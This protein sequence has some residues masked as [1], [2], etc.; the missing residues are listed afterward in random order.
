[1]ESNQYKQKTKNPAK[2]TK[3]FTGGFTD[4][5]KIHGISKEPLAAGGNLMVIFLLF[6]PFFLQAADEYKLLSWEGDVRVRRA[7]TF[8]KLKEGTP[9][10][11]QKGDALW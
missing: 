8:L 6:I 3:S 2:L 7:E 10:E 11:L 1:M 9:V 4:R 5:G